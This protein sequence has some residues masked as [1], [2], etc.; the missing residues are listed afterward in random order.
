VVVENINIFKGCRRIAA[1]IALVG[2]LITLFFGYLDIWKNNTLRIYAF[3]ESNEKEHNNLLIRPHLKDV[4]FCEENDY[5]SMLGEELVTQGNV[6]YRLMYCF[7]RGKE[8][9]NNILLGYSRENKDLFY[10]NENSKIF[11]FFS[12]NTVKQYDASFENGKHEE[13]INKKAFDEKIKETG[14]WVRNCLIVLI[15]YYLLVVAIGW[16]VRGFLSI[17]TG[18]DFK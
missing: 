15:I 1:V 12:D 17:E 3:I 16:T 11:R 14:E 4:D 2:T 7:E 9:S 18:K 5:Y 6:K 8:D 13:F 10:L